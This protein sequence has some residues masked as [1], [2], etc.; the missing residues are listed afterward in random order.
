MARGNLTLVERKGGL[1]PHGQCHPLPEA[2]RSRT[3]LGTPEVHHKQGL[4]KAVTGSQVQ[5]QCVCT[6]LWLGSGSVFENL[7]SNTSFIPCLLSPEDQAAPPCISRYR[8]NGQLQRLNF[9]RLPL[10]PNPVMPLQSLSCQCS[11]CSK[12][13]CPDLLNSRFVSPAHTASLFNSSKDVQKFICIKLKLYKTL[14]SHTPPKTWAFFFHIYSLGYILAESHTDEHPT[15]I[16]YRASVRTEKRN[17]SP[18]CTHGSAST[19]WFKRGR[20]P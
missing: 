18:F 8:Q 13:T 10:K 20:G 1:L 15:Y 14:R 5:G 2:P 12:C 7:C 3:T 16:C 19:S 6:P 11:I 9:F 4:G 17:R